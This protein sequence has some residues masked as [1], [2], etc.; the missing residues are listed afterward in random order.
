M[1][2]NTSMKVRILHDE[3][4]NITAVMELDTKDKTR[5]PVELLTIFPQSKSFNIELSDNL[6]KLFSKNC[7]QD[8]R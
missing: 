5:P 6:A 7:I 3:M 8:I 1:G 2:A 4:G